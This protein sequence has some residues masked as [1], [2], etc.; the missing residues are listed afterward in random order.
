VG[1]ERFRDTQVKLSICSPIGIP[2]FSETPLEAERGLA[3]LMATHGMTV[4]T[5]VGAKEG[6]CMLSIPWTNDLLFFAKMQS[7][8]GFARR[9][10]S[11]GERT[12]AQTFARI[13]EGSDSCI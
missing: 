7:R 6:S 12:G 1:K 8:R 4:R 10:D 2:K 9:H 5:W 11:K 13:F 3:A